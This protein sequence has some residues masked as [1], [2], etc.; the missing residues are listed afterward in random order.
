MT[1][2][3][4]REEVE[5]GDPECCWPREF[6][7]QSNFRPVRWL[8]RGGRGSRRPPV[9]RFRNEWPKENDQPLAF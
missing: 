4:C 2:S 8:L 1:T 3:P 6:T 9:V 7:V 5:I